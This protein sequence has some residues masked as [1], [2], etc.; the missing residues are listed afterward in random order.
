[1]NP[2]M[3]ERG[4]FLPS[5]SL[6][7]KTYAPL[8]ADFPR[9]HYRLHY[10]VHCRRLCTECITGDYVQGA[11]TGIRACGG[12]GKTRSDAPAGARTGRDGTLNPLWRWGEIRRCRV[13]GCEPGPNP[14]PRFHTGP[15]PV[16]HP[17]A[18]G[19]NLPR[20]V[21]GR[22]AAE[23]V[24]VAYRKSPHPGDV[25]LRVPRDGGG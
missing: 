23:Q 17:G 18:C 15:S 6:P 4:D 7:S 24:P 2:I 10:R 16:A 19:A 14:K 11:L 9:V 5:R 22:R 13:M 8:A 3:C 25:I 12:P 21:K 20:R 1:M